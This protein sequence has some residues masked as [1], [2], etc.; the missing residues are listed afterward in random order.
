MDRPRDRS[1]RH[2]D[3]DRKRHRSPSPPERRVRSSRGTEDATRA[4]DKDG[5]RERRGDRGGE[6]R[7]SAASSAAQGI[8]EQVAAQIA[9]VSSLL[10]GVKSG[11]ILDRKKPLIRPLL[12]DA[13]GREIDE[14]GN[15]VK[16]QD[17]A[18]IKTLAANVAVAHA[19]KKRENPYLAHRQAP[20]APMATTDPTTRTVLV[21]PRLEHL[22]ASRDSRA[23]KAF[24]FVEPGTFVEEES[25]LRAKEERKVV[26]GYSSGRRAPEVCTAPTLS[27][28]VSF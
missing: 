5:H 16:P 23:K 25:K 6:D 9:S 10:S 8:Q 20:M 13:Q 4:S 7:R 3:S 22:S 18:Q 17:R 14:N 11:G 1:S 15:L 27:K 19:Q 26:A 21:D 28:T 2:R 12:L 24:Q